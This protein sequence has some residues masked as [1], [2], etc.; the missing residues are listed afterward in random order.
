MRNKTI[1]LLIILLVNISFLFSGPPDNK[2]PESYCPHRYVVLNSFMGVPVN[3]DEFVFIGAAVQPSYLVQKDFQRQNRPGYIM[4]GSALG[5][6]IYY[7]LYPFHESIKSFAFK[8]LSGQFSYPQL[9]KAVLYGSVYAG[10][11]LINFLILFLTMLLFEKSL[12]MVSGNWKNQPWLFWMCLVMLISNQVTKTFFWTAHQQM[13]TLFT[14]VACLYTGLLVYNQGS[15]E[16]PMVIIAS[17]GGLLLLVY[18][19]FLLIM[20]VILCSYLMKQRTLK[21]A[22][23]WRRFSTLAQTVLIF[24]LPTLLW[25]IYLRVNGIIY[26]NHEIS[27][28]RH[29]VWIKDSLNIS[30]GFFLNKI[31]RN[32]IT[33]LQTSGS[34]LPTALFLLTV[35]VFRQWK[36]KMVPGIRKDL[37]TTATRNIIVMSLLLFLAFLWL[38]GAYA[39]RLTLSLAPLLLFIA[40]QYINENKLSSKIQWFLGIM[41]LV[42]HVY[43]VFFNAPHFSEELF[44]Q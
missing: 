17:V 14:P 30:F 38:M 43:T 4:S 25:I 13:F 26:Y 40:M 44:F 41:I 35:I 29:F 15:A 32:V 21:K 6:T 2:G 34:L 3:C 18:G 7:M 33:F 19:N 11:I 20:A 42:F 27:R 36:F 16:K 5:Y 8:K 31:Y 9:E 37:F 12:V 24:L 10:F 22:V 39:D 1:F 28:F 23:T